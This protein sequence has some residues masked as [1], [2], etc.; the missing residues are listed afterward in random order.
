MEHLTWTLDRR[1]AVTVV[2]L[3]GPLSLR[4]AAS[5]RLALLTWL[6]ECPPVLVVELAGVTVRDAIAL[7]LFRAVQL[8][9]K[10]WPGV[11]MVLCAAPPRLERQ[12]SSRGIDRSMPVFATEEQALAAADGARLLAGEQFRE[13]Y[14]PTSFAPGESRELV[15]RA[16]AGWELPHLVEPAQLVLSELVSNAVSHARTD[17]DV[18]VALRWEHLQLVVRDGCADPPRKR[19]GPRGQPHA[20]LGLRLIEDACASWGWIPTG[21]GKAVWA[22]L[23]LHRARWRGRFA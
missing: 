19:A 1:L 13:R 4:N 2:R 6:A 10:D 23:P 9:A 15:R 14:L 11:P 22:I 21:V 12:L 7:T 5:L 20:G 3:R 18:T 8:R 17:I 16:C